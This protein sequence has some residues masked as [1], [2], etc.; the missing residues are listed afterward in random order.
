VL[1]FMLNDPLLAQSS[2]LTNFNE[3]KIIFPA[4][5][6]PG[7]PFE[8]FLPQLHA[9]QAGLIYMNEEIEARMQKYKDEF[10]MIKF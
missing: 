1:A 6:L 2:N 3:E 9:I 8:L 5:L 4:S 7:H 10:V